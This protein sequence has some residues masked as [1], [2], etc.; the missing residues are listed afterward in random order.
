MHKA[1]LTFLNFFP[2]LLLL[3]GQCGIDVEPE[4][5]KVQFLLFLK[6]RNG[7]DVALDRLAF[8]LVGKE[9]FLAVEPQRLDL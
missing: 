3:R 4:I 9:S 2:Y 1:P 8:D 7:F 6:S 5:H